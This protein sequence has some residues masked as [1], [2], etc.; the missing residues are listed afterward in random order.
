MTKMHA[1]ILLYCIYVIH[2]NLFLQSL[3]SLHPLYF[4]D[5]IPVQNLNG[6]L[7]RQEHSIYAEEFVVTQP[8]V[9]HPSTK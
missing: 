1:R 2:S 9:R 7:P 5:Q 8:L 3:F 6:F 4:I